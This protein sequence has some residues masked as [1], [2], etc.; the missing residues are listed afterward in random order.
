MTQFGTINPQPKT[1]EPVV[2]G[3]SASSLVC[4]QDRGS[5]P[6]VQKASVI[7]D[8]LQR[9]S[10][11]CL[12]PQGTGGEEGEGEGR[13]VEWERG[14]KGNDDDD[15]EEEGREPSE[16]TMRGRRGGRGAK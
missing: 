8:H 5:L 3:L 16:M 10:T 2:G 15:E 12:V 6:P 11:S 1:S 7:E 14:A 9:P 13:D 4:R